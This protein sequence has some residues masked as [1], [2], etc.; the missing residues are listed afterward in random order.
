VIANLVTASRIV[1]LIPLW[2]LMTTEG[3][4]AAWG[5]LA[6]F[7][8]AGL[9]DVVDGRI[10]RARGEASAFG[11]MLDLISDRL[12]TAVLIVGLIASGKLAGLWVIPVLIL[13]GRDLVV[14]SFGEAT[15][16]GVRFPVT[17]TER[18]KIALQFGGFGLLLAPEMIPLQHDAGRWALIVGAV[19]CVVTLVDYSRRAVAA[20]RS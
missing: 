12:L 2:V 1:L 6:T 19:V 13:L 16:G 9:T 14:A 15:R 20:L 3:D 11:A 10:A 18:V 17:M 7:V 8:V 4:V 5:A